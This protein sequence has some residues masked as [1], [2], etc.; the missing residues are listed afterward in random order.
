MK[1]LAI[2]LMAAAAIGM[3]LVTEPPA[4]E[5]RSFARVTFDKE[6][7]YVEGPRD[8]DGR[9]DYATVLNERLKRGVT[10]DNNSV[11]LIWKAFGPK[12]EGG[13]MPAKFF[14]LLGIPEPPEQGDYFINVSRFV[15]EHLKRGSG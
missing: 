10:T 3:M 11:V 13:R 2:G 4:G 7:M 14:E 15:K 9:I 1:A 6:T 5:K 8:K 12:P